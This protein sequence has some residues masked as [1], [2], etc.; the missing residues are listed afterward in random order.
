LLQGL[1]ERREPGLSL[2]IARGPVHEH[3]YA[4]HALVLLRMRR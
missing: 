3:A 2:R 4:P 1:P